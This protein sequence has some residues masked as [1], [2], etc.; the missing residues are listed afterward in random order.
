LRLGQKALVLQLP[1]Q[2]RPQSQTQESEN[3]PAH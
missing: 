1:A 2:G 3:I